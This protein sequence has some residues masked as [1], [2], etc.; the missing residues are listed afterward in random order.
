[1]DWNYGFSQWGREGGSED[2][3]AVILWIE[4]M[5]WVNGLCLWIECTDWVYGSSQSI[6][7]MDWTYESSLWGRGG[8]Y[9]IQT[10]SKKWNIGKILVKFWWKKGD[11]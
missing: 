6:E 9:V 3:F 1:M 10:G 5:E 8:F 4:S 2:R 7:S 11:M